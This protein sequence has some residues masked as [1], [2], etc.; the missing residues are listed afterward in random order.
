MRRP[1]CVQ[2]VFHRERMVRGRID[3]LALAILRACCSRDQA[4]NE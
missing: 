1:C 4:E 3:P 2:C